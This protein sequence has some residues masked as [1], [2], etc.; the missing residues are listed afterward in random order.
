MHIK[1]KNIFACHLMMKMMEKATV[2]NTK[3]S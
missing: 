2:F 3:E 1:F